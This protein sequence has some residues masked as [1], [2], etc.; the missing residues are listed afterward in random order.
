MI[1]SVDLLAPMNLNYLRDKESVT[2]WTLR[3]CLCER[4]CFCSCLFKSAANF[5]THCF[6]DQ[7]LPQSHLT[8]RPF[9]ILTPLPFNIC[10]TF[11][12]ETKMKTGDF[13]RWRLVQS[14]TDTGAWYPDLR[15]SGYREGM[16][17]CCES[18]RWASFKV[19]VAHW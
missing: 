18:G 19:D 1:S 14:W 10:P 16:S 13:K 5:Q 11:A 8:W 9:V 6:S 2:F 15:L 17:Q 4:Q 12:L 7:S 3:S